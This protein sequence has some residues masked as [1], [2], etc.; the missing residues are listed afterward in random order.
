MKYS[1]KEIDKTGKQLLSSK[2]Q[3]EANAAIEKLNDWR[4]LHLVPLDFLQQK[5]E[6]F[7]SFNHVHAFLI[8]RRLKRLASIKSK[9]D[10][11]RDMGLG[12]MQDFGGLRNAY[13]SYF[14]DTKEFTENIDGICYNC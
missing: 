8:S 13:P 6:D 3:D 12:G 10:L 14:L 11:N 7:L 9:L 5:I 2:N 1:R 4:S